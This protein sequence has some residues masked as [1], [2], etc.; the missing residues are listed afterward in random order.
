M[1]AST[2]ASASRGSKRRSAATSAATRTGFR[3][4][5]P[6]PAWNSKGIP[7]GSSGSSRSLKRMAAS[8]PSRR[9]GW[10]V[11]STA[12][13]G[14][15]QSVS[16]VCWLAEG[17]VLGQV[18]AGLAHEPDGG[19]VDRLPPAG[20]KEPVVHQVLGPSMPVHGGASPRSRK[21]VDTL[22]RLLSHSPPAVR[23]PLAVRG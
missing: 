4:T 5:G 11:T 23:V 15:R 6:S 2:G 14:V 19:A 7:S 20:A 8:T 17:P 22:A 21:G 18:A 10:S 12:S 13:S 1:A 3:I 16:S 9:T